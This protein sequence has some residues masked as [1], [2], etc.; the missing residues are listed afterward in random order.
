MGYI[1]EFRDEQEYD[2]V[3][4]KM[5]RAKKAVCDAWEALEDA[6][7]MKERNRYRGGMMRRGHYRDYDGRYRDEFDRYN[8]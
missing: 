3:V 7:N 4:E 6:D 5:H 2:N 8:Y 1:L